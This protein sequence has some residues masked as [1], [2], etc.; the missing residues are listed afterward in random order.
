[1]IYGEAAVGFIHRQADLRLFSRFTVLRGSWGLD[2][3]Y[4]E[5]T[6]R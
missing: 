3:G 6:L 1:M 2:C 5:G 4:P